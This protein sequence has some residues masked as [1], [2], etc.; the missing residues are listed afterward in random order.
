MARSFVDDESAA[1]FERQ[2]PTADTGTNIK[3]PEHPHVVTNEYIMLPQ[4]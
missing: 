4:S 3:E 2:T 1:H